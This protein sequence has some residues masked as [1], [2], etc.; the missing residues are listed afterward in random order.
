MSKI[1]KILGERLKNLRLKR[2]L[3]QEVLAEMAKLDQRTISHV[4]NGHS[5]SIS[6][7]ETLIRALNVDVADFFELNI[8]D[9]TDA[10][11]ISEITTTIQTLSSEELRTYYKI[12]KSLS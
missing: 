7:L 12:L 1:K 8:V 6:S 11:I 9:K 4:E 5:L 10:E 3:T 2:N